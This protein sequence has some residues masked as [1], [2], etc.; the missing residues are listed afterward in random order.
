[1]SAIDDILDL[2]GLFP[3]GLTITELSEKS[4]IPQDTVKKAL[5]REIDGSVPRVDKTS[6]FPSKFKLNEF[7]ILDLGKKIEKKAELKEILKKQIEEREKENALKKEAEKRNQTVQQMQDIIPG[8]VSDFLTSD[9][10]RIAKLC[11]DSEK[12]HGFFF[13]VDDFFA[14]FPDAEEYARRNPLKFIDAL[15]RGVNEYV[16]IPIISE[17]EITRC[18]SKIRLKNYFGID[19]TLAEARDA[20]N[21]MKIMRFP[22]IVMSASQKVHR[23]T[24][25]TFQCSACGAIINLLQDENAQTL[26]VPRTCECG[27]KALEMICRKMRDEQ[28]LSLQETENSNNP[29]TLK[30]VLRGAELCDDFDVEKRKF[31]IGQKLN[32]IGY[33]DTEHDKKLGKLSATTTPYFVINNYESMDDAPIELSEGDIEEIKK[34]S[35]REDLFEVLRSAVAPQI[36]GLEIA[37]GVITLQLFGG[38]KT[39]KHRGNIHILLVGDPSC[40]KTVILCYTVENLAL[41]GRF[42]SCTSASHIGL[43]ASVE[44]DKNTGMW[45]ARAGSLVLASG[46]GGILAIDELDKL[47]PEDEK[48]LNQAMENGWFQ[49]DKAAVHTKLSADCSILAAANPHTANECFD[50]FTPDSKQVK[51]KTSFQSRFDLIYVIKDEN[52]AMKDDKIADIILDEDDTVKA[53]VD[54]GFLKKYVFYARRDINP[55]FLKE[56]QKKLKE[57][58]IKLRKIPTDGRITPR[59]LISLKRLSQASAKMR[60]SN[61]VEDCDIERAIKHVGASMRTQRENMNQSGV[62]ISHDARGLLTYQA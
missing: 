47:P 7:G 38:R 16:D 48:Y 26:N 59:D 44:C 37:K 17:G 53:P 40:G 2:L 31:N 58:W 54:A 34:F 10:S 36:Y 9:K 23:V 49:L 20:R 8:K 43:T 21:I 13:D 29:V 3:A 22:A 12:K 41:R 15:D 42:A 1:M 60:L 11:E 18:R 19:K 25:T 45:V 56:C 50:Q 27:G 33:P 39:K 6:S 35:K 51:F 28:V 32:F 4:R 62:E 30:A 55:V 57:T 52:N 5:D 14:F 24:A 46:I 61:I